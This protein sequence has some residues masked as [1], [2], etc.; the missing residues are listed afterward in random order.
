MAPVQMNV[1]IE[2]GLKERGDRVFERLGY[3]PS[4]VVRAVWEYAASHDDAPAIV[5]RMLRSGRDEATSIE[6]ELRDFE[7]AQGRVLV[8]DFCHMHAIPDSAR[9]EDIDYDQVLE[10]AY[11]DRLKTRGLL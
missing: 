6:R 5:E 10:Q 7:L 3:T 2:A 1:R 4:Q 9:P 8:D 11:L